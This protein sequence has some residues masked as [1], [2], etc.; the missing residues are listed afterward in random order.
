MNKAVRIINSNWFFL[1]MAVILVGVA[2][3]VGTWLNREPNSEKPRPLT[4]QECADLYR[5][6][7]TGHQKR[8]GS[9]E[10]FI[11]VCID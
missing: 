8:W 6:M 2:L 10:E 3:F 5:Q 1:I 11:N 7:P 4:A 9:S